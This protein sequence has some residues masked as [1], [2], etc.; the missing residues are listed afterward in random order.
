MLP[1]NDGKSSAKPIED[2]DTSTFDILNDDAHEDDKPLELDGD[3]KKKDD[4]TKVIK[5]A[6]EDDEKKKKEKDKK[7]DKDDDKEK[8]DEID[9]LEELEKELED[10]DDEKLEL[11]TPARR[12]EIL[13]KFPTLFKEFPWMEKMYYREQKF[14]E[15]FGTIDDATQ[16]AQKAETLDKFEQELMKGNTVNILK[17]VKQ[18]DNKAFGKLVD[19][20]LPNLYNVDKDA[21]FHV[22]SN[23]FSHAVANMVAKGKKES[24]D[25]M[26]AAA[27]ILNEFMFGTKEFRPPSRISPEPNTNNQPEPDERIRQQEERFLQRQLDVHKSDVNTK[28]NNRLKATIEHHIDPK[29]SMTAYV[30][31][32]AVRDTL[33][34]LEKHMKSDK[35]VSQIL[36]KLW[37][38]A[39]NNDFDKNEMDR[40]ISTYLSSAKT[41]LP[42]LIKKHRNE[43]LKGMGKRVSED[44]DDDEETDS[45]GRLP[46]GRTTSTR[47][48]NNSSGRGS[49]KEKA[50]SIPVGMSTRD[51]LMSDD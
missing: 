21:Y 3:K 35:R 29:S 24:N 20:Y 12:S 32:N 28:I 51:F 15:M 6:V 17:A 48:A 27:E 42:A 45:K 11:Q 50:K 8:E 49:D 9:E 25:D 4:T 47:S 10:V 22:L 37:E 43:A 26:V 36:D 46:V 18:E 41:L 38:R 14:T 19:D 7:D 34:Q 40:I 31:T 2:T 39:I 5:E 23:V 13:K 33:E 1:I 44:K 30:K 16:V